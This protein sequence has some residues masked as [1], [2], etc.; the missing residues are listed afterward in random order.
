MN[1]MLMNDQWVFEETKRKSKSSWNLMEIKNTNYQSCWNTAKAVPRG[2]VIV[3]S[4]YVK[5][6]ERSQINDLML[7]L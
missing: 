1:N 6:T 7:Y 5:S 4:V 3:L 2:N